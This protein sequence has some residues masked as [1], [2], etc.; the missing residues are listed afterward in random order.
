MNR[1]VKKDIKEQIK[2]L[3]SLLFMPFAFAI[4]LVYGMI[5]CIFEL[6]SYIISGVLK[7]LGGER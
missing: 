7:A 4:S 1:I 5:I 3:L 2:L 6:L